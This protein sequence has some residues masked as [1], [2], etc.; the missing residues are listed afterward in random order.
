MAMDV[1]GVYHKV[2]LLRST[3]IIYLISLNSPN[4][5]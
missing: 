2:G 5:T 3:L 4:L 1:T